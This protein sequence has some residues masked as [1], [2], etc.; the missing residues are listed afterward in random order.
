MTSERASVAPAAKLASARR[1]HPLRSTLVGVALAA[2][3][4]VALQR[5]WLAPVVAHRLA[6]SSGR[7]VHL[8][9]MWLTLSPS[10]EPVLQLR[11]IRIDNAPWA[12]RARPFASLAAATLVF[13][14]R[15]VGERR[16]VV[17]LLVLGDGELDL[18]RRSDGLR[19]W[20][21]AHPD[22]RGPA[23]LKVLAIRGERA[24]LRFRHEPLAL[25]LEVRAMPNADSAASPGDA[26]P[27]RID[28]RGTWR[29]APFAIDAATSETVT[30]LETGRMFTARGRLEADGARLDVDGRLGDIVR[31]PGVDAR[32]ELVASP[33]RLLALAGRETSASAQSP[34]RVEGTLRGGREGYALQASRARLGATDA[35][36]EVR[37]R[38]GEERDTLRAELTS[39]RLEV[40]DV[41]PLLRRMGGSAR[42]SASR[43]AASVAGAAA[44]TARAASA[45]APRPTDVELRVA[46]RRVRVDGLPALHGASLDAS[47]AGGTL[48]V[49]H[50][51]FG[52]GAGRF[53]GKGSIELD[54]R[55][56]RVEAEA[57]VGALPIES[58]LGERAARR[59]LSGVLHGRV[60]LRAHGE[61]LDALLASA[62]GTVSATVSNGTIS[63]LLDAQMG[64]QGGRIVKSLVRG[65]EPIALRCAAAVLD[66]RG[67]RGTIR[68]LV[69]DT[70]RTRTTASG[71]I[72]LAR[73][74][75][76]VVLTPEAKQPG[77]FVLDR[78]IRVHGALAEPGHELVA[79]AAPKPLSPHVCPARH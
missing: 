30:L 58:L 13:S 25:D 65:A 35:A 59:Q 46:A 20:R 41:L 56:L 38:R 6:A 77:L 62:A 24:T 71:T 63:S 53:A 66:V 70:E 49:A 2:L 42:A 74:T 11:G 5:W 50:V 73:R 15:S 69:V 7:A 52:V 21:L 10:L 40:G 28:A 44:S 68:S 18:E 14:W 4:A 32:I 45:P 79:R 76:D 57:D 75:L 26:L 60:A 16:P 67:G 33:A 39:E 17:S 9:A 37:W 23:R 54:E 61:S 43:A 8:D 3:V 12:D 47:L 55:P 19:N 34:L 64:L 78:S 36:G 29:G 31:W 48:R 72:D 1:L 51:A 27:T 22:D